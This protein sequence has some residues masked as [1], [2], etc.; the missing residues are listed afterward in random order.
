MIRTVLN[1]N[2]LSTTQDNSRTTREEE[3]REREREREGEREREREGKREGVIKILK[4]KERKDKHVAYVCCFGF[5]L[6]FFPAD[7]LL[8]S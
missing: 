3:G 7:M 4:K 6:F 1:F 2:V 8:H 5:F